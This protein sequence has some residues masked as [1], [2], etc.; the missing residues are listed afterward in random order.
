MLFKQMRDTVDSIM[1]AIHHHPFN[2]ELAAGILPTNKFVF[3]LE[4]DALYLRDYSRA[5]ALTGARLPDYAHAEQF[6]QFSLTSLHAEKAL[7]EDYLNQY[8]RYESQKIEM[9]STCFM[10]THFLLST[11]SFAS[12]EEASASLLPC[13]WV[14][15][16][17]GKKMLE[18]ARLE[19][20]PYQTWIKLYSSE[21]FDFS[22]EKA[23][24][25]VN[26]L[27]EK[28]SVIMREKMLAAFV[29]ATQLEWM[30]WDAAYHLETWKIS[31]EKIS[32]ELVLL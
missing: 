26:Q 29:K 10:Y 12:V 17:V 27:A 25:I 15:R 3:Y 13:F 28:T 5:L 7:H 1:H 32:E 22:V 2:L 8:Q 9:N 20:N 24:Q 23:I 30:F 11:A 21:E 31:R 4:Q 16:E 6:L 19:N 18:N 14:Y